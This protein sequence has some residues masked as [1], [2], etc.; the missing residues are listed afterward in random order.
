MNI[1]IERKFL[2]DKQSLPL[3]DS[4][5]SITQ[6]YLMFNNNQ[7]LRVRQTDSQYQL[8]YKI[9][10][11]NIHRL[12]FEYD[13]PPEDG[14][15]L[16]S[17]SPYYVI[18]KNRYF[19]NIG[20]H[21]WEIDIFKDLNKGLVVAEVELDSETEEIDIPNWVGKEISDDDRYLNFNLSTKPY[22]LW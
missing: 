12:E 15:R 9:K 19:I 22:S 14:E 6:A 8:G 16:I 3:P 18:K 5:N 21:I 4:Y 20:K 1:E 10:K 17:L 13:I 7:V 2:V 11:T